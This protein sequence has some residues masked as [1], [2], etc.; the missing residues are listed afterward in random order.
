VAVSDTEISGA[1][2][3]WVLISTALVLLMTPAL[4]LF[5][6]GL[7]RSKNVLSTFMHCFTAICLVT[8]VWVTI[9]YSLAFAPTSP[10]LG[11][12]VI[13]GLDHVLLNGVGLGPREGTT[14]PHLAFS[15]YQL[16]FAVITPALI[17]GAYAE[18]LKFS[19]YVLFTVLW[20]IVVYA[21]LCHWV[22]GPGGWL[23]ARG[24][25]DF[26]GGT[27]VHL[28]SGASAIVLARVLGPRLGWPH[29]K[30]LPHD[31]TM[32]L[33]GAGLL[34][35]GWFGFNAGSALGANGIAALALINTHVAA[36]GGG[37]SWAALEWWRH[38]KPSALGVASGLVAGLVA[39]TPAAGFCGPGAAL[40]LGALAGGV[41]FG[42]V[43]VKNALSRGAWA[44][45]D[46][47]DAFGVH[48][49]GGAFGA[50]ATGVVA[51][52]AWNPAGRDGAM[53]GGWEVLGENALGVLVAALWSGGLSFVLA[54]AIDKLIGLRPEAEDEHEGLDLALH[55]EEAYATVGGTTG[56][57]QTPSE[58]DEPASEAAPLRAPSG[59]A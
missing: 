36:A 33:L 58:E 26:A 43:L 2:T 52:S 48:G 46:A 1:D 16:M 25:L 29:R 14:I 7:V 19:A 18:R 39:I 31:L 23:L 49:V 32:T 59:L 42:A 5:Y 50:L 17:A 12:G 15:A 8:L 53:F 10:L 57:A 51:S 6:G 54:K 11:G 22:W 44:Y 30:M 40:V 34:W 13:G 28:S 55:G 56:Y 35:F 27:V 9:G 37:L 41:C 45:D 47:L 38:R 4:A 3:V 21:P 20:T 24:A